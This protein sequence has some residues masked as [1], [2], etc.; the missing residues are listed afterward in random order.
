[1]SEKTEAKSLFDTDQLFEAGRKTW[2]AGLGLYV[3]ASER[4][5]KLFDRL[6][7]KGKET[8]LP[9]GPDVRG[10]MHDATTRVKKVADQVGDKVAEQTVATLHRFG[11]PTREDIQ[12]LARRVDQ[13]TTKVDALAGGRA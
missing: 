12:G 6:V 5:E 4:A 10:L 11:V 13:L 7:E 9:E 3:M 2:L 1:M 8:E